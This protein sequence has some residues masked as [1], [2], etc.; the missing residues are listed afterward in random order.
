MITQ[1]HNQSDANRRAY[2]RQ[3][4][5][6]IRTELTRYR[7]DIINPQLQRAVT[8]WLTAVVDVPTGTLTERIG[9]R[10]MQIDAEHAMF[11]QP[12]M[13]DGKAAFPDDCRGC[14]HYGVA[15]P[16]LTDRAQIARRKRLMREAT[17][18]DDLRREMQEYAIQNGC[19][20][21]QEELQALRADYGPILAVGQFLLMKVESDFDFADE[22]ENVDKAIANAR[23]NQNTQFKSLNDAL[24][25]LRRV[26]EPDADVDADTDTA[27]ET[28]DEP[29]ATG[30]NGET[31]AVADGGE[32]ETDSTEIEG[33]EGDHA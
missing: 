12:R 27:D 26:V 13:T 6:Y 4:I 32:Q 20:V 30:A 18:A 2:K 10:L 14:E 9:D 11:R 16:V 22:S 28:D 31:P 17:D 25:E 8:E 3:L 33:S 21:L 1:D 24:D 5:D 29:D 19:H 23:V 7:V 15:C